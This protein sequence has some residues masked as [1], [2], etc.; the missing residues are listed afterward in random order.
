MAY[1]AETKEE[2]DALYA[3][4]QTNDIEVEEYVDRGYFI[5][6]YVRDPFGLRIEFANVTPGFTLDEPVDELGT[7]FSLP[8]FLE[9]RRTEIETYFGGKIK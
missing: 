3:F 6:L 2:L 1:E 8:P 5:S 7:H 9:P 4:A